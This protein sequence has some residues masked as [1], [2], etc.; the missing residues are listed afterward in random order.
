MIFS[1][2]RLVSI[3]KLSVIVFVVLLRFFCGLVVGN[4]IERV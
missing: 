1:N 2:S 4:I 3:I